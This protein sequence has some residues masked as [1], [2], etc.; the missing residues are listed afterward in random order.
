M[1]CIIGVDIG[2]TSTKSIA[3]DLNGHITAQADQKYPI[4]YPQPGFCEQDPEELFR[5]VVSTVRSVTDELKQKGSRLLALS[6]SGAMHSLIAVDDQ[7]K[8][9]TNAII[10][11]DSRSQDYAVRIR[12]SPEG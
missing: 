7:G 12:Q 8:P 4:L 1:D 3:F 5:A 6:F 2:T 11:A 10:W 9:I